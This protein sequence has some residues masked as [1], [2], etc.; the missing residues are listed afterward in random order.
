MGDRDI[1][2]AGNSTMTEIRFLDGIIHD[3]WVYRKPAIK[4]QA[5]KNYAATALKRVWDDGVEPETVRKYAIVLMEKMIQQ[6]TAKWPT[7]EYA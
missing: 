4:I 5:L 2:I 3:H 1:M 7:P 6:E